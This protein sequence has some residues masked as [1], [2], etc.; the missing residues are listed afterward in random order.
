MRTLRRPYVYRGLGSHCSLGHHGGHGAGV[1]RDGGYRRFRQREREESSQPYSRSQPYRSRRRAF[2]HSAQRALPQSK[3]DEPESEAIDGSHLDAQGSYETFSKA[4]AVGAADFSG[5]AEAAERRRAHAVPLGSLETPIQKL[6]RLQKETAALAAS[7]EGAQEQGGMA[8][9]AY[10][11]GAADDLVSLQE[12]LGGIARAMASDAPVAAAM[13]SSTADKLMQDLTAFTTGTTKGG[14]K[15]GKKTGKDD[16]EQGGVTYELFL[17]ASS[18]GVA[19]DKVSDLERRLAALETAAGSAD[20][21]EDLSSAVVSLR[22]RVALLDQAAMKKLT[23]AASDATKHLN[24]A[25]KAK[26]ALKSSQTEAISTVAGAVAKWSPLAEDLP[27][28]VDR[29]YQLKR[30][31]KQSAEFASN[32]KGIT[33]EQAAVGKTLQSQEALLKQVQDTLVDNMKTMSGNLKILED[34]FQKAKIK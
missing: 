2:A 23:L 17:E 18:G 30:V 22:D 21:P 4:P 27:M 33:D 3:W 20:L 6:E 16:G 13:Q 8:A 11:T 24:E 12:K 15:R 10:G 1:L 14:A 7:M 28:I 29:L 31:H 5:S 9:A 26:R 19:L 34:R 32:F 25:A